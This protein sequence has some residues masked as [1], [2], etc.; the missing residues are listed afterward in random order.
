LEGGVDF[1]ELGEAEGNLFVAADWRHLDDFGCGYEEECEETKKYP[2][3]P[4]HVIILNYQKL[5]LVAYD[6]EVKEIED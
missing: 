4:D 5:Q 1:Y 2:K 3:T 6:R